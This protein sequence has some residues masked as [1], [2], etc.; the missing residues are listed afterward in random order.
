[1]LEQLLKL[2]N[3]GL[4]WDINQICGTYKETVVHILCLHC[5][6]NNTNTNTAYYDCLKLVLSEKRIK[7]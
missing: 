5:K 6:N 3:A 1:M 2:N 4:S 7:L